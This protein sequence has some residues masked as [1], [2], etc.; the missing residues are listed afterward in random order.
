MTSGGAQSPP[1]ALPRARASTVPTARLVAGKVLA[2]TLRDGAYAAAVLDTELGRAAQLD[3]R[4]RALATEL[5]YGALRMR[6]FLDAEL[7]RGSS[8]GKL[9][10]DPETHAHL[11]V[12]G[13]QLF[14]LDR[15]PAFAAVSEAVS[16]VRRARGERVASFANAVLRRLSERAAKTTV[17]QRV[18]A[19]VASAPEWL[20]AALDRALGAESAHAFLVSAT[21]GAP[22]CLRV[23]SP[24]RRPRVA[25]RIREL[26]PGAVVTEGTISPLA[27]LVA[28]AGDPRALL[29]ELASSAE[30]VAIQEE[31]SQA[32]A[33]S[34]GV[35][36]GERVLDACAGRGNK[37]AVLAMAL[38]ARGEGGCD[39]ADVH[40]SKLARLRAELD[41]QELR[42]RDTFAVDWSLGAG[43]ATGPYDAILVDAPCTGVGTLRRRPDLW[44]RRTP[45]ALSDLARLQASILARTARLLAPGGRLVYSVCSVLQEE[46]EDVVE[47]VLAGQSA[48]LERAPFSGGVFEPGVS[49]V[50]L[51]P[52]VH[53]TDGYF[54]AS[55]RRPA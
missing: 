15:V 45:E 1:G 13:F 18:E 2:R 12:C 48:W 4:D 43:D 41:A 24:D 50:R 17:E 51:L 54:V 14:G 39:A 33:L 55:L 40:P 23:A 19:Q 52:H 5:V 36:P 9:N 7:A 8:R 20:R 10:L 42:L 3:A 46:A 44:A 29:A 47:G 34:L 16:L 21:A 53:G 35:V 26:A 28:G 30:R 6:A 31:G 38:G 32:I 22:V 25:A 27:V 49:S 11:L 37:T